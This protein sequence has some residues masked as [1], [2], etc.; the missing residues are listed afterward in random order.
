[1][2]GAGLTLTE[3]PQRVSEIVMGRGP[4]QR[5]LLPRRTREC[6]IAETDGLAQCP[7]VAALFANRCQ[8]IGLD[9]L[10]PRNC[11]AAPAMAG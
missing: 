8:C 2:L 4:V 9:I 10:G 5:I 11:R 6:P 7:I 1:M 3:G